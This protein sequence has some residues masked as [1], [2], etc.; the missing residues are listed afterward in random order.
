MEL[1]TNDRMDARYREKKDMV[2][3][4]S[5]LKLELSKWKYDASWCEKG[6]DPPQ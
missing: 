5:L 6:F 1:D 3:D 4:I 2:R